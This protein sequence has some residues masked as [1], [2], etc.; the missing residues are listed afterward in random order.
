MADNEMLRREL[1]GIQMERHS[2]YMGSMDRQQGQQAPPPGHASQAAPYSSDPYA[3]APRTELPPLRSISN[4]IPNGPDSMTGVQYE[5][6]RSNGY[7]Q[8]RY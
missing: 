5:A 4:G 6:P 2:Q 3:S 1:Q 7:R 8:E